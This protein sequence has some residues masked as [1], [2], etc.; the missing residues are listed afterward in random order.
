ML[1]L[2]VYVFHHDKITIGNSDVFDFDYGFFVDTPDLILDSGTYIQILAYNCSNVLIENFVSNEINQVISLIECLE[3]IITNSEFNDCVYPAIQFSYCTTPKVTLSSFINCESGIGIYRSNFVNISY[4]IFYQGFFEA[5]MITESHNASITYNLFQNGNTGV[6]IGSSSTN[7]SIHHN[8]FEYASGYD[9][10]DNNTWYD[11][12][13]QE[14]NYWWDYSGS[15]NYTVPGPVRANDTYP[16]T[17]PP[18]PKIAE[19]GSNFKTTFLLLLIPIIVVIP[20]L[21][22]RKK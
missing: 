14:G 8:T 2:E 18:I 11:P 4:C 9:S 15:G 6:D 7:N 13:T 20:Y 12:I 10:G 1:N 5:I 21:R 19:F 3:P 17:T 22:K 16:L